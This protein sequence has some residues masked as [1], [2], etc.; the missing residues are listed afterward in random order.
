MRTMRSLA[1]LGAAVWAAPALAQINLNLNVQNAANGSNT[2]GPIPAGTIVN[3][4]VVG[5]LTPDAGQLGLALFG[6]DLEF[7]GGPLAKANAFPDAPAPTGPPAVAACT[8]AVRNFQKTAGIT[9]PEGIGGT[10]IAGKLVQIGG[11]QNTIKNTADNAEFP[12][13]TTIT[14]VARGAT[15]GGTQQDP[16][17]GP[18]ILITGSLTAPACAQGQQQCSFKL[19][20][21]Q[22]FA[23]VIDAGQNGTEE[24]WATKAAGV[25]TLTDLTVTVAGDVPVDNP[26]VSA[27]PAATASSGTIRVLS[28]TTK[29]ET[30]VNF[31]NPLTTDPPAGGIRIR[32]MTAGGFGADIPS[33][34]FTFTRDGARLI[35]KDNASNLA[36]RKWYQVESTGTWTGVGA[37]CLQFVVQ[38]GDCD[39]NNAVNAADLNCINAQIPKTPAQAAVDTLFFKDINGG[40]GIGAADLNAANAQI[41]SA[42]VAKPAGHTTCP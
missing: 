5:T 21:S 2:V 33:T 25:G 17:C 8:N 1:M 35:I 24:F 23:N 3:Y 30:R 36:H 39:G 9:N 19:K 27:L 31:Q 15:A 18:A 6:F 16:K 7:E 20:A 34:N 28:R 37:F 38:A 13:G 14:G 10:V 22:V 41:P 42:P 29:N 26:F 4:Q 12:V 40:T 32:E 11:G